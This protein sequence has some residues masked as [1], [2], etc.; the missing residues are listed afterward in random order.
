MHPGTAQM[1]QV[2]DSIYQSTLET[3]FDYYYLN[4]ERAAVAKHEISK[5]SGEQRDVLR[6]TIAIELLDAGHTEDAIEIYEELLADLDPSQQLLTADAR[7]YTDL[8][9][10]SY[11]RL[12]EQQNCILNNSAASCILPLSKEAFHTLTHG[13]QQ[14]IEVYTRLLERYPTDFRARWML[15]VA[16]MTLGR[17]PAGIPEKYLIPGLSRPSSPLIPHFTNISGALGITEE[18]LAGGIAIEDFNNDGFLDLFVTAHRVNDM[19]R[20]FLNDGLGGFVDKTAEAGLSRLAGGLNV[21]HADYNNDGFMDVFVLRGAWLG[22]RGNQPNSLLENK[23]D[24]TFEDVTMAAGLF[25]SHPTQAA[26]WGDFNNDGWIDLYIGNELSNRWLSAWQQSSTQGDKDHPS[27]LFMNNGDGTFTDVAPQLG[28]NVELFIKGVAWGD[29]NNDGLADLYISVMGGPNRFYLNRGGPS[30]DNW[31]FDEI[32]GDVGVHEPFFS[33][34]VW[35]WDYNNDGALDLYVPSYEV[36]VKF[37]AADYLD[38]PDKGPLDCLYEGK[39]DGTFVEVAEQRGLTKTTQPM[40]CN[41]G[42]LDN[43]GFLD[44][45]LGTGYIG[46]QGLMPNLMF[47]NEGGTT[48]RD[49]TLPGGFGHLQKGHGIAFVDWDR[50]GDQDVFVQMGGAYPGDAF[51]NVLFE[52]PGFDN[53]WISIRLEG[54]TSNR[55]GIGARIKVD[56]R[57]DG[58]PRSIYR[59]INSGGSFGANPLRQHIGVGLASKIESLEVYWPTTDITQRFEE[60]PINSTFSIREDAMELTIL[61]QETRAPISEP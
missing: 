1:V 30:I 38:L 57:E 23:G 55:S 36:G 6:S 49:V 14:A 52:N 58:Q 41:F 56:I 15:N 20:L 48:F 4:S 61:Q 22:S 12:G 18:R 21:V 13:S 32:A 27:Q 43:D 28:L 45:Y 60:V 44:I 35:F 40:G 10:I 50:D 17:Y 2:L 3:P 39:S 42:D 37:V 34:P 19:I 7:K 33:F 29:A 16:Y 24:G 9:A 26:A 11:L 8:L 25:T 47:R 54:K 31:R 46:Y 5:R 53:H 59:W 51:G